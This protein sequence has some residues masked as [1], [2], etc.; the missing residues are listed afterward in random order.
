MY[1]QYFFSPYDSFLLAVWAPKHISDQVQ[2]KQ[3]QASD[4]NPA[5]GLLT[6][7]LVA[8]AWQP[9]LRLVGEENN[10]KIYSYWS[11]SNLYSSTL[12]TTRTC[13]SVASRERERRWEP[14]AMIT[15]WASLPRQVGQNKNSTHHSRY[16]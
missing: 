8:Q 6:E 10:I 7:A 4:T 16:R 3:E 2:E 9:P 12:T 5:W 11:Q 15:L 13:A 1:L 14:Q